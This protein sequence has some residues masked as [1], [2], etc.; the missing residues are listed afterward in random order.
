MEKVEVIQQLIFFTGEI[1]LLILFT[2]SL[3]KIILF[4]MCM[5]FFCCCCCFLFKE[6]G[7]PFP[8][9]PTLMYPEETYILFVYTCVYYFK[10]CHYPFEIYMLFVIS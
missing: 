7:L 1:P 8:L 4:E 6:G 2:F 5:F 3:V 10:F 9:H